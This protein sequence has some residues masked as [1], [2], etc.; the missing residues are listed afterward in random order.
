MNGLKQEEGWAIWITGLPSSGKSMIA[1]ALKKALEQHNVG[2]EV[3]E[4]D[5]VRKVVTPNPT[6][7]EE[8]R[9]TF[10]RLLVYVGELLVKNGVNVIFDATANRRMY[11]EE[12][13]N[14]IA[15]FLEVYVKCP[16]DVCVRR[17][18]KGI[19]ARAVKGEA[20]SVPGLQTFYEEP[21]KPE[22]TLDSVSES[23][24]EG[25][26]RIMDALKSHAFLK[27]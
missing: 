19:Y 7:T 12:A 4:S 23:P 15:K 13:R 8:E 25:A 3:L 5:V 11:R 21:L 26:Q 20:K 16:L 27:R 17:D 14:L 6:F 9:D 2:A 24:E 22:V 1:R 18:A 10:Y